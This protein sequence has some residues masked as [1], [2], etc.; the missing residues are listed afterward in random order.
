MSAMPEKILLA[1]S[2]G[3]DSSV[4][5]VL[6]QRAGYEVTGAF[7]RISSNGEVGCSSRRDADDVRRV[8]GRLGI[9]LHELDMAENFQEIISYFVSEYAAGRTP[10]PCVM[11]N[12]KFKFGRLAKLADSLGITRLAT[13]HYALRTIYKDGRPVIA[14]GAN[15]K[16]DQSY[17]LFAI[18][19]DV[20]G[21]IVLPIGEQADKTLVRRMAEEIGLDVHDKPDS[22]E[23]CFVQND[24][25]VQLVR[26]LAPQAMKSGR[27]IDSA[28][29]E[30][31]RHDG[32]VR[33][34]IGQRRGLR[35]AAG[36]PMYVIK[37][38]PESGDVTIG[39]RDESMSRSLTAKNLNWH[40][41]PAAERFRANVQIRYNHRGAPATVT[42]TG[43]DSFHV[44]FDEGI[45][46]ITPG[47]AAVVYDGDFMLGGGFICS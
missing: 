32:Y 35:V 22:Q 20:I 47:Q 19:A 45:H 1:M 28:G 46:A 13:G 7:M 39:T 3:V 9:E 16:K 27:I 30:L 38:D 5:A 43:D 15:L 42:L 29:N 10:N 31:G 26:Q 33:Y 40:I 11:C 23:I 2:G 12:R 17:V 6:L 18:N 34:T 36:V 21:R 37:I 44:E 25:Y 41:Q 8:A 14:R 24:D 4:A